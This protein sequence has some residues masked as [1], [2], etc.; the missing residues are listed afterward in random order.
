MPNLINKLIIGTAQ[1]DHNYAKNFRNGKI[2]KNNFKK[3]LDFS[4]DKKIYYLDTAENYKNAHKIIG[5]FNNRRFK[6]ITKINNIKTNSN[7][8]NQTLKKI[9]QYQKSLQV[10]KIEGILFHNEK[11]L[12]NKKGEIIYRTLKKLKKDGLLNNIGVSLYEVK[13]LLPII[14]KFSLDFIQ[15]PYNFFDN[16][17]F[18]HKILKI[19]KEKKIKIHARSIFLRGLLLSETNLIKKKYSY[20][21]EDLKFFEKTCKIN[22]LSKIQYCINYAFSNNNISKF[23]IGVDNIDRFKEILN[24]IKRFKKI[25]KIN[26]K[27]KNKLISDPRRWK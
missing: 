27:L 4:Y 25:K 9:Q 13:N 18:D 17:F 20:F 6:I 8:I 22:K 19:L 7:I 21:Y 24:S 15:I 2:S 14:N 5:F 10:N 16:R 12:L 1:L 3:I 11:E 26:Y 23:V